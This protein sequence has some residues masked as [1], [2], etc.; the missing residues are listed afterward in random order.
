MSC[1]DKTQSGRIRRL[2]GKSNAYF[3]LE[4]QIQPRDAATFL[5]VQEGA[6]TIYNFNRYDVDQVKT[7]YGCCPLVGALP[8]PPINLFADIS[9]N[10]VTVTWDSPVDTGNYPILYYTVFSDPSGAIATGFSPLTLTGLAP[11]ITYT[12]V[13]VAT[14]EDGYGAPATSNTITTPLTFPGPPTGVTADVSGSVIRL[15]WTPPVFTGGAPILSYTATSDPSG[16]ILTGTSPLIF[17]GLAFGEYTFTVVATNSVGPS[18]PSAP[19]APVVFATVPDP[20]TG[21]TADISGS[22]IFL[23]WTPPVLTG[24][25]PILSY[26]ATS[27]PIGAIVTGTSPLTITNLV[28]GETYTFTVVAT[29]SVGPS[30][31]SASSAPVTLPTVPN[32]PSIL[33]ASQGH[34]EI[35]LAWASTGDGGSAIL[36]YT[37]TCSDGSIAPVTTTAT[38]TTIAGLTNDTPYTFTI[39]ATNAVGDSTPSAASSSVSPTASQI[40]LDFTTSNY[41]VAPANSITSVDYL[42]VGGGGGGGASYDYAGAGGGAG[43][44]VQQGTDSSIEANQVY[45]I[46]VGTGGAGGIGWRNIPPASSFVQNPGISGGN[47]IFGTITASGGGGGIQSRAGGGTGAGGTGINGG[48]GGGGGSGGGGGGGSYGDG[49]AKS[50][51]IGGVGGN[52]IPIGLIDYGTGG[53]GGTAGTNSYTISTT[54][55]DINIPPQ[56]TPANSGNGGYGAGAAGSSGVCGTQGADGFVQIKY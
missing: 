10:V 41:W 25:V 23:S 44:Q 2:K 9:G 47:S 16:A 8:D 13:V 35:A 14:T 46:T 48:I 24:G 30:V 15:L 7:D 51:S 27:D 42:V 18:V 22:V 49:A 32:A 43:G 54:A 37:I 36:N 53:N 5:S 29:N 50:G 11:G 26:T 33:A 45:T 19:S 6:R 56:Q 28:S 4:N 52:G 17:S 38:S 20:P 21:V 3:Y 55:S 39:V 31:P 34:G 40:I 1:A 12:F